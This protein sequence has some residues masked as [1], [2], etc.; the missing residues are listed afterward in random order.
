MKNAAYQTDKTRHPDT[1]VAGEGAPA[2]GN[3]E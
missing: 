1:C 3:E 2:G